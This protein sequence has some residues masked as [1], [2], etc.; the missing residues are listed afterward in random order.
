MLYAVRSADKSILWTAGCSYT[1][2]VG[3]D[4]EQ[5]YGHLLAEKLSMPEVSLS[6]GGASI[7]WAADQLLR[8]D[9]RPGDIVVWGLTESARIDTNEEFSLKSA[10]ATVYL[11]KVNKEKHYWNIDYFGSLSQEVL[12]ARNVLQVIHYFNRIGVKLILANLLNSTVLRLIENHNT[13]D[14]W[15][16]EYLDLGTD[17]THPGPEQHRHY[18]NEIYNFIKGN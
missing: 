6:R 7:G 18:S 12:V 15:V 10:P 1:E 16:K 2:G 9:I 8:S 4:W 17:N 11:T 5:R 14:L 13:I 3:V